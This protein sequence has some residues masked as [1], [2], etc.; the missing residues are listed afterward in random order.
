MGGDV[1]SEFIPP[2]IVLGNTRS[3]TTVVQN[4][5]AAHPDVVAWYEPRNLWQYADPGRENDEFDA[6]D[7][8]DRVKRYI[9]RKFLA[10]QRR[11]GGRRIVEKTPVNILRI[12]YVHA[13]FPDATYL[14]IVRSPWSFISSVELKWQ[15]TVSVRGLFWRFR[16]TPP[17]QLHHYIAKYVRQI[18]DKRILRRK[19][20]S[21]WG[22]RYEGISHDLATE[23]MI[24]V[25]ARQW[26]IPSR[27][28]AED[29]E[30]FPPGKVLSLRYEDLV[31]DPLNHL[32]RIAEHCGLD[33]S[34]E[35][36][37]Y[38][39]DMIAADRQEKWRRM[40]PT[41]LATV[42]HEVR[43]EMIRH[44]Y[45]LP[46]EISPLPSVTESESGAL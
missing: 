46:E 4:L 16:S 35:M 20:L 3:G 11:N 6:V 9:R 21:V 15:R 41:D 5:I 24:T 14:Y 1:T 23:D 13:I 28:A 30:Q 17:S 45:S 32:A 43:E 18:W 27:K 37:S 36:V 26:S 38:A 19:Y 44:S 39:K 29:L 34:P 40:D 33:A 12:P 8:T 2:I 7:A 10:Y 22:P 25:V 42:I 31:E